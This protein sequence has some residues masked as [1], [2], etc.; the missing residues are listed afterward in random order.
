VHKAIYAL[1]GRHSA[2]HTL[3]V[4]LSMRV[5][6]I[7]LDTDG[8]SWLKEVS[9]DTGPGGGFDTFKD[10][11]SFV[12][13]QGM[14]KGNSR[15]DIMQARVWAREAGKDAPWELRKRKDTFPPPPAH[16]HVEFTVHSDSDGAA[17]GAAGSCPGTGSLPDSAPPA[18]PQEKE[19]MDFL[20]LRS[21]D[22]VPCTIS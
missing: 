6:R 21:L 16:V 9:A 4:L 5:Y 20:C 19:T 11:L 3:S 12:D 7:K 15:D 8:K 2:E 22:L 1:R 14:G 17:G 13:S 10:F 18:P